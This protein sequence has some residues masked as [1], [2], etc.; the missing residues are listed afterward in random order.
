MSKRAGLH[1]LNVTLSEGVR[2]LE[3]LADTRADEA[4]N[5]V[6]TPRYATLQPAQN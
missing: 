5:P 3:I 1:S 6:G 2:H 4:P